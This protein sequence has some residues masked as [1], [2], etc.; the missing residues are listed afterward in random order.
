MT[1]GKLFKFIALLIVCSCTHNSKKEESFKDQVNIKTPSQSCLSRSKHIGNIS[2]VNLRDLQ[3][4]NFGF[5]S[6]E[7]TSKSLKTL[8]SIKDQ[9]VKSST[10]TLTGFADSRGAKDYNHKL[11]KRRVF[12]VENCL[13]SLGVKSKIVENQLGEEHPVSFGLSRDDYAK[14]R[15][16]EISID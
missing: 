15:R 13:R 9:V 7:I 10:I 16:V 8:M 6:Y 12:S 1:F 14:N 3:T 11:A 4:V 2:K 5:D